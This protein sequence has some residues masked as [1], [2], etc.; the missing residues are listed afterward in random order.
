MTTVGRTAVKGSFSAGSKSA[1]VLPWVLLAIVIICAFVVPLVMLVVMAFRTDIPGLPG[2]WS[3]QGF[4]QAFTDPSILKPLG[5]S[6]IFAVCSSFFGTLF[7]LFF[8][9]VSTRTTARLRRFVTPMMIIIL[10][11][12]VLFFA[13]SWGMLGADHVGLINKLYTMLTGSNVSI[14]TINSWP[15]LIFVMSI[16]LSAFS[17]F[18]LLGPSLKMNRSL[19]EAAEVSGSGR[20]GTFFRVYLPLLSPAIFGSLLVGFIGSLQAFDTPQIIGTQAGIRV[21]STEIYRFVAQYPAN[22]AGAASISIGLVALLILLVVLQMRLLRGRDYTTVGGK[23]TF[24]AALSFPRTGW[25]LNVAIVV[26]ATLAFVLP[27]L[28]LV[29]SSF[30]TVFGRYDGFSLRNYQ[31]IFKNPAA[32][33]AVWNTV[34]FMVVGGFVTVLIGTIMTYALRARPNKWKRALELPTWIPWAMPGLVGVLAILGTILTIPFLHPIYGS[35]A[36]LFIALV[37]VSLPIAMRFTENAVLQI[38][39][40]LVDAARISGAS[41]MTSF[42]TILLPLI[43]PSFI[44][45]WFVTGLA[46][47]GNLEVPLLLGSVKTTTI[48]GL[49]YKYYSDSASPLAAAIFCIL[50]VTVLVLF[51]ITSLIR[52]VLAAGLRRGVERKSA[53]LERRAADRAGSLLGATR[54]AAVPAVVSHAPEPARQN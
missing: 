34:E 18:L 38:D 4:V 50:L 54:A 22:Y 28:Q 39:R 47:A 21:L 51:G 2:E 25:L 35:S 23:S 19:E 31:T 11:T 30:N 48:A 16:K 6:L 24:N 26:F 8:V 44:S 7:A 52:F 29:L 1:R 43:G 3:T 46:I 37:I 45:G 32:L 41:G 42:R 5:D 14:F 33:S 36:A 27:T 10:A 20:A 9:F 15:G 13:L 17:Y 49:A 53:D 12:P 40:Q